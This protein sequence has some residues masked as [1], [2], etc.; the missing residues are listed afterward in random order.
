MAMTLNEN[1][2][3]SCLEQD[4]SP[5]VQDKIKEY[6]FIHRELDNGEQHACIKQIFC[7]LNKDLTQIGEHRLK[8]WDEG[9]REN[10]M[11]DTI[12]PK[13]FDKYDVL[14]WKQSFIKP[15]SKNY[16]V[17]MLYIIV[18][19]LADKYMRNADAVYEFGCGTGHNLQHIRMVNNGAILV[20]LDWTKS[21]QEIIR[22][23]AENKGD[24]RLL[25][26]QFDFFNPDYAIG[27]LD[28]SIIYTV[29]SLEQTAERYNKFL[30]YLLHYKPKLCIHIEPIAE[31]LDDNN[32]LD[33]L[34][35]EYFKKR[36][37]LSGFLTRLKQ[38]ETEER[39]EI[40]CTQ[41]TYI[42]SLFIEGY[43]VII[44]RI[45]HG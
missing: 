35:I 27:I 14:R 4:L 25:A 29:A 26:R 2:F 23:Y 9:W 12:L 1:D 8:Q 44:W 32:L 11:S 33:Y 37:Y 15:L 34:S 5:Y 20:G 6:A 42:G 13:Y 28:N 30:D 16:E 3:K 31:L 24:K 17:N 45:K 21:S 18:D 10:L 36:N 38:L 39:I 40:I 19:W 43:S 22:R 7:E 41:R